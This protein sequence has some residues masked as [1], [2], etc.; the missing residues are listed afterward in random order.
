MAIQSYEDVL[1]LLSGDVPAVVFREARDE[2]KEFGSLVQGLQQDTATKIDQK[3]AQKIIDRVDAYLNPRDPQGDFVVSAEKAGVRWNWSTGRVSNNFPI[4]LT[5]GQQLDA[6]VAVQA[7][8][9]MRGDLEFAAM[10]LTATGRVSTKIKVPYLTREL[11]NVPVSANLMWGNAQLPALMAQTLLSL[12]TAAWTVAIKDLSNAPN[13][14]SP[15]FWGRRFTDR[16]KERLDQVRRAMLFSQFMHPYV[17]GPTMGVIT[18]GGAVP[19]GPEVVIANGQTITCRFD[20]GGCDY[21][22]RWIMDDSTQADGLEPNLLAQILIGDAAT[23]LMD[24][25][26][27]WRDFV[28]APTVS[29][30]GMKQIAGIAHGIAAASCPSPGT[31]WSMLVRRGTKLQVAFTNTNTGAPN[32]ITLRPGLGGI[33]LYAPSDLQRLSKG[34]AGDIQNFLGGR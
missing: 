6:S 13:T 12:P 33:A 8:G 3:L 25:P 26:I 14:V 31:C 22:W 2:A 5:A 23:P 11:S 16:A 21:D 9:S 15:V 19:G 28:A 32:P 7:T 27:S 10:L 29:V 18:G 34:S 4:Q 1:S 17:I 20:L 24:T 30:I